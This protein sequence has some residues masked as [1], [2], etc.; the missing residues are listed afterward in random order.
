M[1]LPIT[2]VA[3]LLLLPSG[4]AASVRLSYDQLTG[5]CSRYGCDP[6]PVN[7][8]ITAGDGD[9]AIEVTG[10]VGQPL[11]VS[12][13]DPDTTFAPG[14]GPER[15][16][17]RCEAA[18]DGRWRCSPA[19][20]VVALL[21]GGHDRLTHA[22]GLPLLADGGAGRDVMTGGP[23]PDE[24][25]ASG[26]D[27]D[28]VDG[29]GGDDRI[30]L[31]DAAGTTADLAAG[32]LGR[33]GTVTSVRDVHGGPGND[34][35]RGDD[36]YSTLT[37]GEGD[38]VIAGRGDDDVIAG[39]PGRDALD[40]GGGADEIDPGSA[41][42]QEGMDDDAIDPSPE[43]ERWELD[44]AADRIACGDGFD[45]VLRPDDRDVVR[46]GCESVMVVIGEFEIVLWKPFAPVRR[47]RMRLLARC[48]E[49]PVSIR[50]RAGRRSVASDRS[51]CDRH[52][53]L[54]VPLPLPR[55]LDVTVANGQ[56]NGPA[57]FRLRR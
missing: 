47:G 5:P 43:N 15:T 52:F 24:F 32:T 28:A 36:G 51:R 17:R 38:D 1:R 50:L 53:R 48:E 21:G 56:R 6:G 29:A 22:A 54:R 44:G 31:A 35:I 19:H 26:T 46:R 45:R 10:G 40:G 14:P 25:R 8:V 9:H 34:V 39:G 27:G 49:G 42:S 30:V 41:D 33:T 11:I 7:L 13:G 16:D 55:V 23:E 18:G 12:T 57:R 2:V 20:R 4:A 3:L 37:G